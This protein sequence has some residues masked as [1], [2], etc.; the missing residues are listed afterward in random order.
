MDNVNTSWHGRGEEELDTLLDRKTL[1]GYL[2]MIL[3]VT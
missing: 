3:A 1:D 2:M